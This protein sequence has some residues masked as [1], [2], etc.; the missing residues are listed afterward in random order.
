M[1]LVQMPPQV[2]LVNMPLYSN[3]TALFNFDNLPLVN[4]YF[5]AMIIYFFNYFKSE[6]GVKEYLT[7]KLCLKVLEL[8]DV[9]FAGFP[10]IPASIHAIA[11]S[12]YYNDK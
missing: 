11:R 10:L 2:L 6:L 1:F 8:Y 5:P 12:Y 3:F 7:D 4:L 9:L